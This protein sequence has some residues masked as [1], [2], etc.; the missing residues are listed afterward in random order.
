MRRTAPAAVALP[1]HVRVLNRVLPDA[2]FRLLNGHLQERLESGALVTADTWLDNHGVPADF[3]DG[4]R[5]WYGRHVA[6]AYR[7]AHHGDEPRRAWVQHRTTDY[8]VPVFVYPS[9][10]P[11][12]LAGA[13]SYPRTAH[14]ASAAWVA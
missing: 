14:L 5:S 6:R 3:R 4:Y 2:A 11:A 12:L 8:W 1:L 9:T 10:A 7:A 13:R